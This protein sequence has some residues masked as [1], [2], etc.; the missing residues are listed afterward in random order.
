VRTA[1][2]TGCGQRLAELEQVTLTLLRA[3]R[4]RVLVIDELH[5]VLA[6]RGDV[7]R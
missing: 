1:R 2:S 4:V 6:G 3:A 5:N 7:R